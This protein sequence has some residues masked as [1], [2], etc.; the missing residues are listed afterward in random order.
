METSDEQRGASIAEELE[1][2]FTRVLAD[3]GYDLIDV[4]FRREQR[5]WVLRFTVDR[6]GGGLTVDEGVKLSRELS[7]AIDA[8]PRLDHMLSGPYHLEVSSPG[9]FRTLRR[10]RDFERA[11]HKRIR[12]QWEDPASGKGVTSVG[13]LERYGDGSLVLKTEDGQVLDIPESAIRQ[14]R[15]EPVLPFGGKK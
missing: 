6:I 5:G 2:R 9:I 1:S 11:W 15:L 8:D 7:A 13:E 10:P 12:V 14:A 3:Q 4:T